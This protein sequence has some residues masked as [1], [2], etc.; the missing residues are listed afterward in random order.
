MRKLLLAGAAIGALLAASGA[1]NATIERSF[2][3]SGPSGFLDPTGP[4]EGW[5]YG[6]HTSILTGGGAATTDVGWGSPGVS[7]G[8]TAS[9][10]T[11][12]VTDFEITF[13]SPLDATQLGVPTGNCAGDEGG[14]TVFCAGTTQWSSVLTGPDSITFNAPTGTSLAPGSD[15]FVNVMLLAGDG[16]SG[17]AF[18][19]AWTTATP[20]PA[21]LALLGFGLAGLGVIR[22]RRRKAA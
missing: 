12:P 13:A 17:E 16:V 20:E 8:E 11:V 21:S 22:R 18:S 3:G 4:S 1:A 9:N 15:Y 10:E 2:S 14:G 5:L 19:G 7:Q 6:A